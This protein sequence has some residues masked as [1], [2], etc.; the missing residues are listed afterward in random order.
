MA[1]DVER[2]NQN[3][4]YLESSPVFAQGTFSITSVTIVQKKGFKWLWCV[5]ATQ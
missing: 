1:D 5:I 3:E 2:S 4:S